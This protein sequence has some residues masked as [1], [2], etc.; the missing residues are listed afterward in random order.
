MALSLH[1]DDELVEF[2]TR[3]MERTGL[4]QGA[5]ILDGTAVWVPKAYP[6]YKLG[7]E[8]HLDLITSFLQRFEN[9]QPMG[10]YGMF[11]YNNADHSIMT[12]LLAVEN[13]EGAD[14]D[15]W[16]VNTDTAYHEI[17]QDKA[18]K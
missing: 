14:H 6:V 7:Y 11:K 13:I 10:R 16:R 2:G 4:L 17:R 9:L 3:E 12:A 18:A 5:N 15:L 8:R 1:G